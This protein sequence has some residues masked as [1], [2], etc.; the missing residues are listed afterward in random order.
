LGSS[1]LSVHP[2]PRIPVAS[3]PLT[4]FGRWGI[5]MDSVAR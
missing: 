1:F 5:D 2:N 3:H 4:D